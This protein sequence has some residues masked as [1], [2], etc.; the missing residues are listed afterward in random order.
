MYLVLVKGVH[1]ANGDG[2]KRYF[3]NGSFDRVES[4]CDWTVGPVIQFLFFEKKQS[5]NVR[6]LEMYKVCKN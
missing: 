5:V 2:G 3:P 1:V 4:Y 6:V